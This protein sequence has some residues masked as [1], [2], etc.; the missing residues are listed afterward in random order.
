MG[1]G[2]RIVAALIVAAFAAPAGASAAP[3]N[4]AFVSR[5]PLS[6]PLPIE[7]PGSNEGA[8]TEEGEPFTGFETGHTVWF[9]WI[10]PGSDWFTVGAC[11]SNFAAGIGIFT[12]TEVSNLTR[13]V[14][15]TGS[16]GPDCVDQRQYTFRTTAATHYLIRVAG[17][18]IPTPEGP[19]PPVEG[20]F[21]L[22]IEETPPPPNDDFAN[23]TTLEAP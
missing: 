15:G 9:E 17:E 4:D 10:A 14:S 5:L 23:A 2:M 21:T 1:W 13:V 22:K 3:A 11:A 19:P 20:S 6:E 8:T 12:G 18:T 7:E 16:E